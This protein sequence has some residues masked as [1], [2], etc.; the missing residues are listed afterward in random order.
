MVDFQSRDT[1]RGTDDEEDEAD[2][3]EETATEG[4]TTETPD[5][6][7]AGD[8]TAETA[9]E[10]ETYPETF[11]YAVVTIAGDRSVEEDA[12]GNAVVDAIEGTGDAVAT[13]ELLAPSYDGIQQ[14]LGKLADRR[15]VDAIVT[16]G[17]EGVAPEDVTVDA[18][19]DLLDRELP[20]FGELFRIYS[21]DHEGTEVVRTRATAGIIDGVPVFCLPDDS[22]AARRGV[23][24]I[25]VSEAPEIASVAA[26]PEEP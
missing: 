9:A 8:S 17:G 2:P 10:Q 26:K 7:E 13:R 1:R 6:G 25:V 24:Q 5:E 20:G 12:A 16:L 4:A 14:S 23:E 22:V 15:D 21:H 3:P 19:R 18:A 11:T